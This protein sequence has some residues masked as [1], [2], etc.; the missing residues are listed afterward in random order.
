VT[1]LV[2]GS[3]GQLGTALMETFTKRGVSAVG[4]T[5]GD[6]EIT[7]GPSVA[8]LVERTSPDWIVT[9]AAMHKVLDCEA[10]PAGARAINVEGTRR[11]T[12][13]ARRAGARV[14]FV[15]TDYVFSGRDRHSGAVRTK[16]YD[17]DDPTQPL[18]QYGTTKA[19]GERIVLESDQDVVVRVA[20][21]FGRSPSRGKGGNFVSR[22]LD[23]ARERERLTVVADQVFSPT[24]ADDAAEVIASL[25][26]R[27]DSR[28][29]Y[30]ASNTGEASWYDL[31]RV[32]VE[33]AGLRTL[34]DPVSA[35]EY[36]HDGVARPAYSAFSHRRLVEAGISLPPNWELAARSHVAALASEVVA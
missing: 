33:A 32:A 25:I 15:S 17:E 31:A 35:A 34:V 16:P 6:V 4:A 1:V 3:S 12:E 18:N 9:T 30:H 22:I 27:A 26:A 2:I 11:V 28:G 7:D 36:F 19:E 24:R 5:H 23:L 10:D 14:V 20:G 29:V 13:A 8:S 21:L